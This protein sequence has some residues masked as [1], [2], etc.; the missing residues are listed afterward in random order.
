MANIQ[1]TQ[2]LKKVSFIQQS[3]AS[4]AEQ[5]IQSDTSNDDYDSD[6]SSDSDSVSSDS[7]HSDHSRRRKSRTSK[8]KKSKKNKKKRNS[9]KNLTELMKNGMHYH[10]KQM[11][12]HPDLDRRVKDFMVFS[13][14][15]KCIT[16]L[17]P[18]LR[19]VFERPDRIQPPKNIIVTHGLLVLI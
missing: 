13:E 4:V 10:I 14:S 19:N 15:L 16:M 7:S 1:S 6:S 11:Q 8:H 2:R 3:P 18:E 17:T 9:A 5:L 12:N